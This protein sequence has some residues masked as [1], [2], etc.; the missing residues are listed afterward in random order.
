MKPQPNAAGLP[1]GG[2]DHRGARTFELFGVLHLLPLPGGPRPSPGLEA[3][4]ARAVADARALLQ[5][6]IRKAIVENL[7][8]APFTGGAVDPHVVSC[9]TAVALRVREAV[10]E[11]LFL[12]V[13]VLRNDV[14][15]ALACALACGAGLVRAN[16]LVGSSWTDQ[17]L[18][19]GRAHEVLRYRRALGLAPD[20]RVAGGVR[21]AADVFVKHGSPAG[22]RSLVHVARDTAGRGGADVLIVTGEGT[23]SP[24]SPQD[25]ALVANAVP[26][27]PVWVGSGVNEDSMGAWSEVAQGAIVGT[28]L[29]G[30]GCLEAPIDARRVE[31]V[32]AALR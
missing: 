1:A 26:D 29:H 20:Q 18:I 19:E 23:G 5:G 27:T 2:A 21:I 25:L 32:V 31:R 16:V 30:D 28:A 7:G 24:C 15:G 13:N 4:A 10:G 17:G 6:G 12:G 3:V 14:H 22:G 8:D 11:E 9:L